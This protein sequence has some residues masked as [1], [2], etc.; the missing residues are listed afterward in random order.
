MPDWMEIYYRLE[1]D[2]YRRAER[3]FRNEALAGDAVDHACLALSE[4]KWARCR[5][6]NGRGTPE[7]Y[8]R[9]IAYRALEEFARKKFGRERPATCIR[10]NG[11]IWVET[12]RRLHLQ[13]QTNAHVLHDMEINGHDPDQ[14]RE[15][16]RAIKA[17]MPWCGVSRRE[18]SEFHY[19]DEDGNERSMFDNLESE[20]SPEA[21]MDKLQRQTLSLSLVD[22]LDECGDGPARRDR[23]AQRDRAIAAYPKLEPLF[24]RLKVTITDDERVILLRFLD[25]DKS[26]DIAADLNLDPSQPDKTLNDVRLRL[27][28]EA[29]AVGLNIDEI[30]DTFHD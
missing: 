9:R 24:E 16:I 20:W 5:N 23:A 28:R 10:K 25:G 1:P 27:E 7:A 21:D 2:L 14:V 17:K 8:L 6:Y 4:D 12:W 26:K 3:R 22:T 13:R 18:I 19:T 15:I 11:E 30:I 29:R